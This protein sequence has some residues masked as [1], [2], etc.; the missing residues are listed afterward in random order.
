[1]AI[2]APALE[3][4]GCTQSSASYKV[5]VVNAERHRASDTPQ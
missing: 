3:R 5:F 1:M 2:H 4:I